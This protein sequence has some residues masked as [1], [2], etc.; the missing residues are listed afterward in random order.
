MQRVRLLPASPAPAVTPRIAVLHEW[1]SSI[2]GSEFV[3][4]VIRSS[5]PGADL[6]TIAGGDSIIDGKVCSPLWGRRFSGESDRRLLVAAATVAWRRGSFDPHDY[7]LVISSHHS[8]THT[9]A[10]GGVPHL[11]YVHSP[12]RYAWYA[13]VDPRANSFLG[14]Q[15]ARR[16]RHQD[17]RAAQAVSDYAANSQT[18][19]ARIK[20]AW[21]RS[22]R[23]IHPPVDLDRWKPRDRAEPGGYLLG[24]SRLIEYKRLDHVIRLSAALGL[25]AVIAGTGP[26]E[27]SLRAQAA[28]LNADVVFAGRIADEGI[29]ELMHGARALVFPGVEDFGLVPVEAMACGV[30]VVALGEGGVTETVIPG[31]NGILVRDLAIDAWGDAIE[32]V[33]RLDPKDVRASVEQFGISQFREQIRGWAQPWL[34]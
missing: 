31:V 25:P 15:L 4:R 7:D 26:Q 11:S 6:W 29:V 30:P 12:A 14:R 17:L 13:D 1:F 16:V 2:G 9:A 32:K 33:I 34:A 19:A 3:A 28:V 20:E 5:F 24:F 27:E 8:Q 23:V 18:T 21:G 10:G 22:A